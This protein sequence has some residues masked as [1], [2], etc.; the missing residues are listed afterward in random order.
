[1]LYKTHD[2]KK[3]PFFQTKDRALVDKFFVKATA[4]L[5]W[6]D[7]KESAANNTVGLGFDPLYD[8]QDF[9]IK[10]FKITPGTTKDAISSATT[11]FTNFGEK[12]T[13]TFLLRENGGTW[14]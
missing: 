3:S 8:G 2:A 4:D 5:I 7:A 9:E 11:E 6:R 10:D 14:K 12:Q 1:E 13:V